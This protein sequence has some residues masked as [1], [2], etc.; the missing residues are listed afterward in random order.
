[1][2]NFGEI[3]NESGIGS[4]FHAACA[5]GIVLSSAAPALQV[6]PVAEAAS[7]LYREISEGSAASQVTWI[8]VDARDE[9]DEFREIALQLAA[10]QKFLEPE[11]D[12]LLASNLEDF[13]D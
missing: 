13:L 10:S 3:G 4:R 7:P 8:A 1:M 11:F 5:F 12:R 2:R 6:Q 9:L